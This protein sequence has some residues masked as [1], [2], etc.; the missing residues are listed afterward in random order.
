M[1]LIWSFKNIEYTLGNEWFEDGGENKNTHHFFLY[2][3]NL[4]S[5]SSKI[6]FGPDS[7]GNLWIISYLINISIQAVIKRQL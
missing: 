4:F 5:P 2:F 1:F 6:G 7:P 3:T